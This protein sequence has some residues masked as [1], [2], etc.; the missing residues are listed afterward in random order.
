MSLNLLE[1]ITFP[2]CLP[3]YPVALHH[4]EFCRRFVFFD[5]AKQT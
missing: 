5:A 3:A 1:C 4:L 2:Y